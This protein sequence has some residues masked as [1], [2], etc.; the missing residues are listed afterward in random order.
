LADTGQTTGSQVT[1]VTQRPGC[2]EIPWVRF[3]LGTWAGDIID[4]PERRVVLPHSLV[5]CD[6]VDHL[7]SKFLASVRRVGTVGLLHISDKHYR[8]R[9]DAYL[10]F[11]WVWR[12]Y[13]HSALA[14]DQRVRQLPLGPA[15]IE[16]IRVEPW[17]VARRTPTERLYTW[18][19]I[20]APTD[21]GTEMLGAFRTID[22]G[23][24][25]GEAEVDPVAYLELLGESVFAPCAAADGHLETS[26]IYEALE[27]GTIPV[28][29]RRRWLD[30]FH[31]LLGDH[32]LPTVQ[33]WSEA[34]A[35]ISG[36]L[37]DESRLVAL[38]QEVVGWWRATK[39]RLVNAAR[40]DVDACFTSM[41][42]GAERDGTPLGRPAPRWRGKVETLRHRPESELL[43]IRRR[44]RRR[45]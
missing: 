39:S 20:G 22:G 17:G 28:V 8:C 11:G 26:R 13:Y 36:L 2:S 16:E 12:T 3:L 27:L 37:A 5:I 19:F 44:G 30:Y 9:L 34:P 4:D 45:G 15:A 6:R 31:E 38:H 33:S 43:P 1:I 40:A 35:V 14:D 32:P 41:L 7:K 24:E 21:T 25:A 23:R 42:S 18:S 29:E 10:S